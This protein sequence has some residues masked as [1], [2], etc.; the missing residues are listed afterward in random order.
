MSKIPTLGYV[1]G[2]SLLSLNSPPSVHNFR[3]Q[4]YPNSI[5]KTYNNTL[6]SHINKI[7][8]SIPNT[9]QEIK[10]L[11][12]RLKKVQG[13]ITKYQTTSSGRR[14]I[15]PSILNR[16]KS[17]ITKRSIKYKYVNTPYLIERKSKKVELNKNLRNLQQNL[18]VLKNRRNSL[19]NLL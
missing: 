16:L 4:G 15:Q 8:K 13:Q 9:E 18:T 1:A 6:R 11:K 2:S 10:K 12:N 19:E 3:R 7:N 5:I 17:G 14:K